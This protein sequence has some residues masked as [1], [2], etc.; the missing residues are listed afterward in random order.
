[1]A[2]SLASPVIRASAGVRIGSY[3]IDMLPTFLLLPIAWIPF[4]GQLIGGLVLFL[5]WLSRDAFGRSL[6]KKLLG[7]SIST[8]D[9]SAPSTGS[10]VLRNLPNALPWLLYMI[11]LAG[12]V[13]L[14][15]ANFFIL[16]TEIIL[17]VSS[18]SRLGDRIAGTVVTAG[19]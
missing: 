19:N 16:L 2:T 13:I 9:G 5:Y 10:L 14:A 11:P 18:N 1:M 4:I 3:L 17:L 6:G 8:P 7:L 12:Y 15:G